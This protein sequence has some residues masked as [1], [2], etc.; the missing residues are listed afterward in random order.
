MSNTA[1][2]ICLEMY[3]YDLYED[4]DLFDRVLRL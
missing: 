2:M 4:L 3:E 1:N